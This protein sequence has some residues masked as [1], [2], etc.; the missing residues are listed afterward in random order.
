MNYH[1]TENYDTKF[2]S[3]KSLKS[4]NELHVNKFNCINKWFFCCLS[5]DKQYGQ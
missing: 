2:K 5:H 1:I 4:L 3:L